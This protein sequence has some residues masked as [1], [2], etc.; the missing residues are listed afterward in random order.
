[1]E[2]PL[3]DSRKA[4]PPEGYDTEEEVAAELGVTPRTLKR[5]R[6]QRVGPPVTYAGRKPIYSQESKRRWLK[7]RELQMPPRTARR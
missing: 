7:S 6:F 4:F 5:W 3:P 2:E 1:M